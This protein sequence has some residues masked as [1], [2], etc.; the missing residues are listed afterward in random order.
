[1]QVREKSWFF[2]GQGALSAS[3]RNLLRAVLGDG[4]VA[5]DAYAAWRR[6]VDWANLPPSWQGL[7]PIL[8]HN[9]TR[10]GIDDP[11]LER[12]RGVRRYK[13]ARNLRL[14]SIAKTVHAALAAADVPVM[15][16]KGSALVVHQFVDRSIRPMEDVDILVPPDRA[17][18][19]MNALERLGMRAA[20]FRR[21]SLLQRVVPQAEI[22]GSAFLT[23]EGEYLDLHWNAM[24]LDRRPDAD[25]GMW[26]RSRLTDFEGVPVR[27]PDPVDLVLQICV[28]GSQDGG[29]AMMRA[30]VD[31]ALIIRA[32]ETFDWRALVARAQHHRISAVMA[33]T[34]KPL[35][36]TIGSTDL[37]QACE[38]LAG[39]SGYG[40][41][42]EA[43]AERCNPTYR[44]AGLT[45]VLSAAA[46]FRRGHAELF[47]APL[48]P[49]VMAWM[50][51]HM[52][53]RTTVAAL[54]RLTYLAAN[55][56][57]ILRRILASDSRLA[58]PA[59]EN[60][61]PIN[62]SVDLTKSDL[63]EAHFVAGWSPAE[64]AGR[65]T[66]GRLATLALRIDPEDRRRLHVAFDVASAVPPVGKPMD[67]SVY[68]AGR[69]ANIRRFWPGVL[70]TTPLVSMV[71]RQRQPFGAVVPVTFEIT[72]PYQPAAETGSPDGRRLG[73]LLRAI[74]V[75]G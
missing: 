9:A 72:E 56:P 36:N 26:Q 21:A 60:L 74:R 17:A 75:G 32:A 63:D 71:P 1:M 25:T 40:E 7:L 67:V 55:R 38:A 31:A 13:W 53:T 73:L 15:A 66:E 22:A 6:D 45:G 23:T 52:R 10:L 50:R 44:R 54:A 59:M 8:H 64:D 28:H 30:I 37:A 47:H 43:W 62:G 16:L 3:D 4:E 42:I 20:P 39:Q 61:T 51:A 46:D 69:L 14:M 41:R 49:V 65:W 70:D 11:L 5:R 48:L 35:A 58:L 57:H 29:R 68:I 19:A 12:I 18:E 33:D 34:L 27:V 24:H 2:G